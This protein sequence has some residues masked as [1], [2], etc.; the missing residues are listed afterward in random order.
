MR[1]VTFCPV[2]LANCLIYSYEM[3]C[4]SSMLYPSSSRHLTKKGMV[5]VILWT[6]TMPHHHSPSTQRDGNLMQDTALENVATGD[7]QRT[8]QVSLALAPLE[9]WRPL[10]CSVADRYPC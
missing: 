9:S 8:G 2:S 3:V 6:P 5:E 7:D 1:S 10:A 4:S